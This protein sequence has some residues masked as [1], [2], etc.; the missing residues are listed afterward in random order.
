MNKTKIIKDTIGKV[1]EK[2][3]FKY[4]GKEQKIIWTFSRQ[5][6]EVKEQVFIQQHTLLDEEYKIMLHTSARGNG[7]KEIGVID[8]TYAGKEYWTVETDEEFVEVMKFFAD[9]I[10]EKCLDILEDMLTEKPDSFETPE[11]KQWFKEHREELIKEYDDKYHI[12]GNGTNY[13]QIKHIDKI[14]RDNREANETPEEYERVYH[15]VLGM[16]A[17]LS[18]IV[19]KSR[20]VRIDYDSYYVEIEVPGRE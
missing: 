5:V 12:L 10:N 14:L 18:E 19:M 1:L 9:F 4:A 17:V 2:L 16:A 7:M 15:F 20:G 8:E 6:G 11:R 13:E 3:D